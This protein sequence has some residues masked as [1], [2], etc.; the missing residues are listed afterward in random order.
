MVAVIP[1]QLT[2]PAETFVAFDFETAD[3]GADSACSMALV[4]FEGGEV[5]ERRHWLIRP[6]RS[7]FRFTHI[8]GIRWADVSHAPDFRAVWLEAR[9]LL[10]GADYL[11]AHNASFDRRVLLASAARTGLAPRLPPFLCTL[12]LAR[13]LW[14]LA[15]Y[16]LPDV[17]A[18]LRLPTFRHHDALAD[19]QACAGIVRAAA[20]QA[21]AAWTAARYFL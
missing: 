10:R 15:S 3:F 19:A 11:A 8:H 4:K 18:H 16:R 20:T 21:R 17:A 14:S 5:A 12:K 9:P 2:A 6:P 7:S 13:H 1:R